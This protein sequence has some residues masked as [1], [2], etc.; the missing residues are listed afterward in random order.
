MLFEKIQYIIQKHY[1]KKSRLVRGERQAKM[2]NRSQGSTNRD[3]KSN[4]YIEE[5]ETFHNMKFY[6]KE[7]IG[8]IVDVYK[9]MAK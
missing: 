1:D 2:G 6:Y 5:Y 4:K 7:M 9:G 3:S 8:N